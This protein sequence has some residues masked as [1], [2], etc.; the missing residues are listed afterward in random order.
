M[1]DAAFT[2]GGLATAFTGAEAL[3]NSRPLTYQFVKPYNDVLLTPNVFVIG[4]IGGQFDPESV[5]EI[6]YNQS[7]AFFASVAPKMDLKSQYQEKVGGH[8]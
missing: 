1:D 5:Y 4:Q 6:A 8:V 7:L 3:L 2:D